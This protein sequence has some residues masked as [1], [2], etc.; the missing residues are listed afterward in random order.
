M[1]NNRLWL[2]GIFSLAFGVAQ[3]KPEL[4]P[5]RVVLHTVAGDV[6]VAFYPNEAPQTVA[7]MKRLFQNRVFEA[8]HFFR[9]ESGFVLQLAQTGDRLFPLT[10]EQLSLVH[11]LPLE[12]GPG[13]KH[14]AWVLSMA[15]L[16]DDLNSGET[17]F[18]ILLGE[19][20]HLDGNYTI[21]GEVIS[22][23][24]AVNELVKVPTDSLNR[25]RTRLTVE[26]TSYF[27][28]PEAFAQIKLAP[29]HPVAQVTI[30]LEQSEATLRRSLGVGVALMVLTSLFAFFARQRLGAPQ[31]VA[32]HLV[33]VLF[34]AFFLTI[35]WTPLAQTNGWWAGAMF[36]A[37]LGVFKLMNRF[38][39]IS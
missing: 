36:L 17:S 29:A 23:F 34:G 10:P 26:K 37:L 31:I 2:V 1:K 19:A 13:V 14:V 15:R 25:P 20:P 35:L 5:E 33:Q 22:G 3:A 16:T 38:E 28:T 8:T 9:R 12:I 11:K 18:S 7:Q 4:G 27:E 24:E 32:L 6:A 39:A 30:P 21:F